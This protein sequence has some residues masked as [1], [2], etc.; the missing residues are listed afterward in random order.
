MRLSST[1]SMFVA[2]TA[3]DLRV[4]IRR[5]RRAPALTAAIVLTIGLGLGAAAAIFTTSQA[6]LIEPLPYSEA[7][8]LVHLWEIREGSEERSPTSYPT[9]LDWRSRANSFGALEGYDATNVTVGL[10]DEARMRRGAQVTW[11][12]FRLLGVRMAAG[13]D[14]LGGEDAT[15]GAGVAIVSEDFARSLPAGEL[16]TKP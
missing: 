7:G 6:A 13:R 1:P 10:G 3:L 14:F 11:G 2:E 9:L 5:M 4:A 15:A 8:R 12:F 16:L